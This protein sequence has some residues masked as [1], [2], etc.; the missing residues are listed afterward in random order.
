MSWMIINKGRVKLF[1]TPEQMKF[2]RKM[3]LDQLEL[4][5]IERAQRWL[6]IYPEG[7]KGKKMQ[8]EEWNFI[9][10][11]ILHKATNEEL[12]LYVNLRFYDEQAQEIIFELL[13]SFCELH[14]D[15]RLGTMYGNSYRYGASKYNINGENVCLIHTNTKGKGLNK[16]SYDSMVLP[17]PIKDVKSIEG[18][19]ENFLV[20]FSNGHRIRFFDIKEKDKDKVSFYATVIEYYEMQ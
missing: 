20:T 17:I 6:D 16:K 9:E 2:F 12:S 3:F 11:Y 19:F 7:R 14:N 18:T 13:S 4:S 15:Y 1:F 10:D 5:T 8:Q